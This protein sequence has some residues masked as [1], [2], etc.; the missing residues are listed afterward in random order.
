MRMIEQE[1]P[2]LT[3]QQP[4]QL[5]WEYAAGPEMLFHGD[6]HYVLQISIVLH[7]RVEVSYEDWGRICAPGEMWWTMCW[8]PHAYRCLARRNLILTINLGMD[9]LGQIG[10]VGSAA[11][12]LAPFAAPPQQRYCPADAGER[13]AL[14]AWCRKLARHYRKP[15]A[16]GRAHCW[17]AL[18]ELVLQAAERIPAQAGQSSADLRPRLDRLQPALELVRSSP[19]SPSLR[20]AAAACRLS[21]SRFSELFRR[22]LGKSYG[23]FALRA[24]LDQCAADLRS[25][26]FVLKEIA[27]RHGFCDAPSLCNAFRRVFK[28][29]PGEFA[30][31]L[32]HE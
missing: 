17:L 11:D 2:L 12:W 7:G 18:H 13:A 10:P 9:D 29:T 4:F 32:R 19:I 21:V 24:R 25:G 20:E 5:L 26:Q 1:H 8:E 22:T 30:A 6:V 16:H 15:A 27:T 28:C 23:H 3:P 31:G 14:L